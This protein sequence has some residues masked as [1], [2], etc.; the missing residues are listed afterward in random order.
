MRGASLRNVPDA[1]GGSGEYVC[2]NIRDNTYICV[3]ILVGWNI[4]SHSEG[5][6]RSPAYRKMRMMKTYICIWITE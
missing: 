1:L 4:V 3:F 6:E 5:T 2:Y